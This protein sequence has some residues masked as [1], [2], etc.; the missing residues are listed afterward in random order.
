MKLR[1]WTAVLVATVLGT[2]GSAWACRPY[3]KNGQDRGCYGSTGEVDYAECRSGDR[4]SCDYLEDVFADSLAVTPLVQAAMRG[5]LK[6]VRRLLES[7]AGTGSLNSEGGHA[8]IAA[9]RVGQEKVVRFLLQRKVP[10]DSSDKQGYT[11]LHRAAS[12]GRVSIARA[13]LEAGANPNALTPDVGSTA[14]IAAAYGGKRSM[15]KLLL[16]RGADPNIKTTSTGN[17]ALVGAA[18]R[19]D[20]ELIRLLLKHGADPAL[21]NRSGKTAAELARSSDKPRAAKLIEGAQKK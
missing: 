15:A 2:A 6:E 20:L 5:K 10:A 12:E 13:L 11:A 18:T 8:L 9:V 3:Y 7:N 21:K 17:F 4:E 1:A 14:L 16:E 19:D